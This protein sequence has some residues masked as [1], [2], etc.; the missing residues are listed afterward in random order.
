MPKGFTLDADG[1][2]AQLQRLVRPLSKRSA[3]I[4]ANKAIRTASWKQQHPGQ[5]PSHD[6]LSQI[7]EWAWAVC[8]PAEQAGRAERRRLG[9]ARP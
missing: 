6:V 2:I 8:R 1:E 5:E 3:Q 9:R 7:D 4:E